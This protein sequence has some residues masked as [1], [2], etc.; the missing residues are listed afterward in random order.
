[1][2]QEIYN[3]LPALVKHAVSTKK[4]CMALNYHIEATED[5]DSISESVY[6]VIYRDGKEICKFFVDYDYETFQI[7]DFCEI[8]CLVVATILSEGLELEHLDFYR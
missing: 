1:M 6:F 8:E 5:E 7:H 3:V 2:M 4:S